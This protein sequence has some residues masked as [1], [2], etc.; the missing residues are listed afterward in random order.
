MESQLPGGEYTGESQLPGAKYTRDLD[1]PVMNAPGSL[2]L[3]V[4]GTSIRTG[5]KKNRSGDNKTRES[6]FPSA[7]I[8]GES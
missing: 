6:R 7:L 1:S 8:T 3:G 5:Y 4:F 2:F